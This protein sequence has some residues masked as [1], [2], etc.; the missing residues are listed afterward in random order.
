MSSTQVFDKN[1]KLSEIYGQNRDV[2]KSPKNA[3]TF[4]LSRH[5][6]SSLTATTVFMSSTKVAI[7]GFSFLE[8]N[9]ANNY[10]FRSLQLTC[11]TSKKS[12][13]ILQNGV[14]SIFKA[15]CPHNY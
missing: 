6:K 5:E 12:R 15:R 14:L 4:D 9:N 2:P 8:G 13:S 3:F 10:L 1:L 7:E 11:A